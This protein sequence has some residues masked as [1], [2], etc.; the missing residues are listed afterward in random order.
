MKT[1]LWNF[2]GSEKRM[3]IHKQSPSRV[4]CAIL[5]LLLLGV[6]VCQAQTQKKAAPE[7]ATKAPP[8]KKTAPPVNVV[9]SITNVSVKLGG[10]LEKPNGSMSWQITLPETRS[11]PE[12]RVVRLDITVTNSDGSTRQSNVQLD[13][14]ARGG[15]FFAPVP[16]DARPV[17]FSAKLTVNG[18]VDGRAF[19]QTHTQTGN[20]IVPPP[21]DS[22]EKF[23]ATIR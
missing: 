4:T 17:S 10:G 5:V 6:V 23:P 12:I 22:K 15:F 1:I 18:V 3:L 11:T 16:K 21:S 8:E 7:K 19:A 9:L 20:V 13:P 2:I 14:K